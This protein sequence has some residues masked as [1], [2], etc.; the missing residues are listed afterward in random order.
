MIVPVNAKMQTVIAQYLVETFNV[1]VHYLV[2]WGMVTVK[3]FTC[4]GNESVI[5][6]YASLLNGHCLIKE[7]I[8]IVWLQF[9]GKNLLSQEKITLRTDLIL[10]GLHVPGKQTGHKISCFK[11]G[12]KP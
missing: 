4:E 5:F 6:F 12:Q 2:C 7:R 1:S 8:S 9:L 11:N 10:E 3:G